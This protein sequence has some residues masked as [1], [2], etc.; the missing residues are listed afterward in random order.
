MRAGS[1]WD[2]VR[3]V[4]K[5]VDGWT[6][7]PT[8]REGSVDD[9]QDSTVHEDGKSEAQLPRNQQKGNA[10]T[11]RWQTKKPNKGQSTA[12][13]QAM[14]SPASSTS[15]FFPKQSGGPSRQKQYHR[16][17]ASTVDPA[18]R[19]AQPPITPISTSEF[20]RENGPNHRGRGRA[21]GRGFRG[22]GG[23]GPRPNTAPV[24]P[25]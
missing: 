1:K 25:A 5:M 15:T 10:R 19:E 20:P 9:E 2:G 18:T 23:F 3:D 22:R 17:A 12:D 4:L 24:P 16:R 8:P 11:K 14:P 6:P 13:Q 21:R 7:P